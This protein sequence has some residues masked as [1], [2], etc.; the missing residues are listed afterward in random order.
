MKKYLVLAAFSVLFSVSVSAQDTIAPAA[1]AV[2]AAAA[3]Q[4]KDTKEAPIVREKF[5]PKRDPRSDL[6]SALVTATKTN[7][8]IILDI[9]GEWCGWCVFMDKFFVQHPEIARLRETNYVWVKVNFSKENEN[10]EFLAAYPEPAGYP[11]LFVLDPS[12]KLL[13]SQDTS[14]LELGKGYDADK[15]TEFLKQWAPATALP[16]A[17]AAPALT[18]AD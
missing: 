4:A 8:N 11:H 14:E 1:A 5:D 6:A 9:G 12:G 16:A 7:K 18:P 17:A 3:G 10:K 15:V 13:K 2:S